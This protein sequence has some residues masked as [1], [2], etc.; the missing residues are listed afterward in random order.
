MREAANSA[1]HVDRSASPFAAAVASAQ[2]G[3]ADRSGSISIKWNACGALPDLLQPD[4][5][6]VLV[7]TAVGERSA[8]RDY[9]AGRGSTLWAYL[10]EAGLTPTRLEPHDDAELLRYGI[11]LTDLV[12]RW[13]SHTTAACP[14]TFRR[15]TPRSGPIGRGSSPL[16]ARR[17]AGSTRDAPGTL[18]R[19]LDFRIGR[20][21]SDGI[22]APVSVRR[23]PDAH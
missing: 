3:W 13:H 20:H 22:R 1:T 6:L 9:Y 8:A 2:G 19:T 23:E 17:P 11:G 18:R 21:R 14:T 7:G 12:K 10:E 15:S 16:R 4:L 5:D